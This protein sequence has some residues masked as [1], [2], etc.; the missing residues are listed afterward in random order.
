[1][2]VDAATGAAADPIVVDRASGR[3]SARA[4]LRRRRRTRGQRRDARKIRRA[5]GA[6]FPPKQ[7]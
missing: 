2:V 3:P 5:D 7:D 1:M 6:D 4:R